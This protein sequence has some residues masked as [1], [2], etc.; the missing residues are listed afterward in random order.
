[1]ATAL[2]TIQAADIDYMYDVV[3]GW[4]ETVTATGGNVLG[5]LGNEYFDADAGGTVTMDTQDPFIRVRDADAFARGTAVTVRSVNY[6]IT[7][8]EPDGEGETVHQL[9]KV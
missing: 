8:V 9:R 5:I 7:T 4:A 6:T 2:R 1:M 3:Y